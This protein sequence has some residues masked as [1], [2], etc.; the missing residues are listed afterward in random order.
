MKTQLILLTILCLIDNLSFANTEN[1]YVYFQLYEHVKSTDGSSIKPLWVTP[2]RYL[3]IYYSEKQWRIDI[4]SIDCYRLCNYEPFQIE[5][6]SVD[7]FVLQ[8]GVYVFEN[9]IVEIKIHH[10]QT[11]S[12][13][14]HGFMYSM[15][16][17]QRI[18]FGKSLSNDSCFPVQELIQK[19]HYS[20]IHFISGKWLEIKNDKDKFKLTPVK[21][22][23]FPVIWHLT[24]ANKN[25]SVHH[26]S[27]EITN[28]DS[29][30]AAVKTLQKSITEKPVYMPLF[31]CFFKN[32]NQTE[33]FFFILFSDSAQFPLLKAKQFADDLWR[34]DNPTHDE[35]DIENLFSHYLTHFQTV[36]IK[37]KNSCFLAPLSTLFRYLTMTTKYDWEYYDHLLSKID[38]L[39]LT[40]KELEKNVY[41][42]KDTVYSFIVVQDGKPIT[43]TNDFLDSTKVNLSVTNDK[44]GDVIGSNK[45]SYPYLMSDDTPAF[46]IFLAWPSQQND[47]VIVFPIDPT[48]Q[49]ALPNQFRTIPEFSA[50]EST[51]L[52]VYSEEV[53]YMNQDAIFP[54]E[55]PKIVLEKFIDEHPEY[56]MVT[57]HINT[58]SEVKVTPYGKLTDSIWINGIAVP[59]LQSHVMSIVDTFGITPVNKKFT[60]RSN[61]TKLLSKTYTQKGDIRTTR[62]FSP[63]DDGNAL[64][65]ILGQLSDETYNTRTMKFKENA[66]LISPG[67]LSNDSVMNRLF[68]GEHVELSLD[69]DMTELVT[70]ITKH[71][72]KKLNKVLQ[73]QNKPDMEYKPGAAVVL[74]DRMGKIK[75][76]FSYSDPATISKNALEFNRVLEMKRN[77]YPGSIQKIVTSLAWLLDRNCEIAGYPT[78]VLKNNNLLIANDIHLHYPYSCK[79]DLYFNDGQAKQEE[80]FKSFRFPKRTHSGIKCSGSHDGVEFIDGLS[81]ILSRSCNHGAISL[82]AECAEPRQIPGTW[83]EIYKLLGW[84]VRYQNNQFVSQ[85]NLDGLPYQSSLFDMDR[86][87]QNDP[88]DL[89][90]LG[91]T[92]GQRFETNLLHIALIGNYFI[93]GGIFYQPSLFLEEPKRIQ[94]VVEFFDKNKLQK[95]CQWISQ[96][97]I[98]TTQKGG[99]AYDP[100]KKFQQSN[101]LNRP[102]FAGKTGTIELDQKDQIGHTLWLGWHSGKIHEN[103]LEYHD[104][105][106]ILAIRVENSDIT[107]KNVSAKYLA[108]KIA[109]S[110]L[111]FYGNAESVR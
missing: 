36:H 101:R 100:F 34:P 79:K 5:P 74:I 95:A 72:M 9:N 110:L 25:E 68:T 94:H 105:Q 99:T 30:I 87:L 82:L 64:H 23:R 80:V 65:L 20:P 70:S 49:N 6:I 15:R 8:E 58:N 111:K 78:Y 26:D 4:Q 67:L 29:A 102:V 22:S 62:F 103:Q 13:L 53:I 45:R 16:N 2:K 41:R 40:Q 24:N 12:I 106:L 46:K 38:T 47:V 44:R 93:N 57:F 86:M 88:S 42:Y 96:S 11:L 84:D 39:A 35:T 19:H 27:I 28:G 75:S 60:I 1:E 32:K 3:K 108:S 56:A 37:Q 71:H 43:L 55:K 17:G 69:S 77:G 98:L 66:I 59:A 81:Q 91:T 54:I 21:D 109:Y 63:V 31:N 33:S 85:V 107:G 104:P 14:R 10:D 48:Q 18:T 61:L 7:S 97:L 76:M 73:E 89:V 52:G 90:F 92:F 50:V 51:E 83:I